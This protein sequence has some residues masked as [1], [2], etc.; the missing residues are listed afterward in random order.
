[1]LSALPWW[2][3]PV[4]ATLYLK[5]EMECALMGRA[6]LRN[7]GGRNAHTGHGEVADIAIYHPEEITRRLAFVHVGQVVINSICDGGMTY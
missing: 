2:S 1:M 4:D 6:R 7:R 5:G 3:Q